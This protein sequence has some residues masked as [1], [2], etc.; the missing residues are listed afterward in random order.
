MSSSCGSIICSLSLSFF[1]FKC[2]MD[3]WQSSPSIL[4]LL[5]NKS[6]LD[7]KLYLCKMNSMLIEYV[8]PIK[9]ILQI[10]KPIKENIRIKFYNIVFVRKRKG[11]WENLCLLLFTTINVYIYKRGWSQHPW[12]APWLVRQHPIHY[13]CIHYMIHLTPPLK[14]K[15]DREPRV[16]KEETPTAPEYGTW[17]TSQ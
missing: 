3:W 11:G 5:S 16:W 17:W 8:I 2:T 13:T 10:N 12:W 9:I 1:S 7:R 15:G 14:L 6:L 4:L